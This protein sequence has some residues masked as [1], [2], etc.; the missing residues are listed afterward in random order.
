M[1]T[2]ILDQ[3]T[4]EQ[5]KKELMDLMGSDQ[6]IEIKN[7]SYGPADDSLVMTNLYA[8]RR[9]IQRE[10]N[11]SQGNEFLVVTIQFDYLYHVQSKDFTQHKYL[12]VSDPEW[13]KFVWLLPDTVAALTT[14]DLAMQYILKDF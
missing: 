6:L 7:S 12:S 5:E 13:G 14:V 4:T 1:K 2:P 3:I 9:T 11:D 8:Q 10:V